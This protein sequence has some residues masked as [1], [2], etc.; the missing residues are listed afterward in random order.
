M[1]LCVI[2]TEIALSSDIVVILRRKD[3]NGCLNHKRKQGGDLR[4][5]MYQ[6]EEARESERIGSSPGV[7]FITYNIPVCSMIIIK[8]LFLTVKLN[9]KN[10]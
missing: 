6:R 3:L 7:L 1:C 5:V 2:V 10:Q 8:I 9:L 4:G